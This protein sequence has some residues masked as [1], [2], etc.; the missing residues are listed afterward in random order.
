[1][2][3]EAV[4]AGLELSPLNFEVDDLPP[5]NIGPRVAGLWWLFE[6]QPIQHLTYVDATATTW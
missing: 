6:F 1:M 2:Y 3:D 4:I 5:G